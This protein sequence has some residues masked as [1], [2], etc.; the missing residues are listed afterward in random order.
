M[1]G[2]PVDPGR[3][4]TTRDAEQAY[5]RGLHPQSRSLARLAPSHMAANF[6]Q[7]TRGSCTLGPRDDGL[8]I[9]RHLGLFLFT[10]Q[11]HVVVSVW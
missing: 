7:T 9:Q 2:Q 5:A 11:F 4:D 8:D 6:A 1:P 3:H 10:R